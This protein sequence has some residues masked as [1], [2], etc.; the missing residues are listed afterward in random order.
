MSRYDSAQ[1]R[2]MLEAAVGV[3][4]GKGLEGATVRLVGQKAGVNSA[5]IYYY[6]ENKKKL[7]EEAIRMVM[8][9]FLIMLSRHKR[10]FAG[11]KE[12]IAFL[13]NGI[14]D[15]YENRPDRMRL[16]VMVFNLHTQ[17]LVN[18]IL[19]LVKGKEILPLAVLQEGIVRKQ[20]KPF[21]PIQLWWN[22][23]GMCIFTLK[24]RQIAAGLAGKKI[25]G[26]LPSFHERKKQIVE[27]LLSGAAV[28]K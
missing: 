7:F 24:A 4:A 3:F 18:I 11:A 13:V 28:P 27:L 25:P 26:N 23:L 5:L 16:M 10:T 6:F 15:Y 12:R 8:G 19:E 2:K 22:I 14:F 17:L 9:D 1:R 21:A 20:L